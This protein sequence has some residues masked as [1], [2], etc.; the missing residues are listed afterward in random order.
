MLFSGPGFQIWIGQ[1][2]PSSH[3]YGINK[4]FLKCFFTPQPC[5]KEKNRSCLRGLGFDSAEVVS[6]NQEGGK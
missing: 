2:K 6:A 3:M 1:V 5:L 4:V